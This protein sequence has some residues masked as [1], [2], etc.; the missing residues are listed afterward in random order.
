[1]LGNKKQIKLKSADG[2]T[3]KLSID[4]FNDYEHSDS[5]ENNL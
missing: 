2:K 1:M 4:L 5:I 3:I